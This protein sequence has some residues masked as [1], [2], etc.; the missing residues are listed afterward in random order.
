MS[1]DEEPQEQPSG[2][3]NGS[4]S[5]D[6]TTER[7]WLPLL[8]PVVVILFAILVIYGLSRIYLELNTIEVGDVTMATPLAIGVSLFILLSAWYLATN[9]RVPIWQ[10]AS[11]MMVAVV[12]LTGG[13]IWAA[14]DDRGDEDHV[15]SGEPTPAATVVAGQVQVA[16]HDPDW[17]VTANPST[18]SADGPTFVVENQGTLIHNFRVVQTDLADDQLPLDDTGLQVDEAN[19]NVVA[20]TED[21]QP[22]DVVEVMASLEPGNYVLFCNIAG[23]YES[24]MHTTLTVE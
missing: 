7:L 16:L 6:E 18:I 8:I 11:I 13:A 2:P 9:R 5:S 19:L 23:H 4:D 24:G 10:T 20:S 15:D 21:F 12:A 22:P 17:A 14:V 1:A 3:R